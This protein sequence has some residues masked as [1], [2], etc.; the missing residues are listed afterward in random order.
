ML[1]CYIARG[2][3]IRQAPLRRTRHNPLLRRPALHQR[4]HRLIFCPTPSSW[5]ETSRGV[6]SGIKL[7]A[8][9]RLVQLIKRFLA[10]VAKAQQFLAVHAQHLAHF[11]DAAPLEA[12]ICAHR[13]VE[14]FDG[15]LEQVR[16]YGDGAGQLA[17]DSS[18]LLVEVAYQRRVLRKVLG[19]QAERLTGVNR[20]VGPDLDE[21]LFAS[22]TDRL[23]IGS[24]S[25]SSSSSTA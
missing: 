21:Q 6:P 5:P 22:L 4:P 23:L 12:V 8:G 7:A 18:N 19:S 1:S 15:H 9:K 14:V 20:A 17:S 10:E 13:E 3:C 24:R 25:L 16:R 11:R 2:S